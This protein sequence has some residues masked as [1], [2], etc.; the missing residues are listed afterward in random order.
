M[1]NQLAIRSA[2]L[3][4]LLSLSSAPMITS[5]FLA[6]V[7]VYVQRHLIDAAVLVTWF[8]LITFATIARLALARRYQHSPVTDAE[9]VDHRLKIFRIGMAVSGVIWGGAGIWLFP[10]NDPQHQMFLIFML[11]G[12]TAGGVVSY[13]ADRLSAVVFSLTVL[14][15]IDIKLFTVEANSYS[16]MG[17]A[18]TLY[19]I[20]LIITLRHIN[21]NT[22]DNIT[23]HLEATEREKVVKTSE[24]RY[25]LLLNYS[26][27]GIFHYDTNLIITYC[28][29]RFA[30]ILATTVDKLVGLDMNQL[31]DQAVL[32]ALKK[33]IAGELGR[34][35]GLY[36]S[37]LSDISVWIDM[38]CAPF[39]DEAAGQVRGG[40]GIVQDITER[41]QAEMELH[42]SAI[43]FES[44][45]GMMITDENS[46]ILRVNKAF[47]QITGY[48]VEEVT[49]VTPQILSS[50]NH[51][52]SF[53]EDMWESV[54]NKG[55]WEGEIWNRRKNG[56]IYPEHLTITAVP[57]AD[58]NIMNYVGTLMDITLSKEAEEEIKNLAF[59]DSLTGLP[60][61]R[62]LLDRLN[63]ALAVSSRSGKKGAVLFL[64]LDNFKNLNDTLGHDTGDLLLQ[65]VAKRLESC[66]RED[67]TVARLGGDEFVIMLE[68]LS[69]K[70]FEAAAQ[71]DV[72]GE[73]ILASI[74]QPYQLGSHSYHSSSSIGITII[75][76]HETETD[77][78]LK[79]ADIAMYQAKKAGRDNLTFF[80]PQMQKS[81]SE[82]VS[83]ETDL[84]AAQAKEQFQLYYQPQ[85]DR[86]GSFIGVEVL[87][88]WIHPDRGLVSPFDFIPLAEETGLILPI[89]HWVMET[90]CNQLKAWAADDD[91]QHLQ[92]SVNVSARQFHQSDFVEV[93][94]EI[95][96]QSAIQ[97]DKL[98]LELTE[99]LVLDDIDDT[100]Q[101]MHAL[102]D[103]GVRFSMDDFGTGHS[104]L[105][106]L[107]KLPLDELKI[108]QSFVRDIMEDSDD[109]IIVQ[110]IIAMATNLGM[111]VIAEGVETDAQRTFLE[112]HGC[113]YY[114]GYLFGRPEPL[115]KFEALLKT[116]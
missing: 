42:I 105:A 62:L 72:V 85:V 34:F 29:T 50:G 65:Q 41:K 100:I 17:V 71:T 26:P 59:Y 57:N 19:L 27:V 112:E 108:D 104:S 43:A 13:S 22:I 94:Q 48:S 63:H 54:K 37:T 97:P 60:N 114:Q 76:G 67:D 52:I 61:R 79:Q 47:T 116:S 25:R 74:N 45:Q 56:E 92:L 96:N 28:N 80:D 115:D 51:D 40:I 69:E 4:Q 64:D 103:L 78:L 9:T 35:E 109:A 107:K 1:N 44:Q 53:Y 21:R 31:K 102:R 11:A 91:M 14:I 10:E 89:G 46:A 2:Q 58:G 110:T 75:E 15:P 86:D 16:A 111:K 68:N 77:E 39:K 99:S 7:L 23:L 5:I 49:G 98:K 93:V 3:Q 18:L 12:L 81:V 6:M 32:P 20:F 87:I 33:V 82:R 90:A 8:S 83:L 95:L 113:Y 30:D 101:K 55:T 24:E 38:T 84:R 70:G 36:Q 73:K 66:V 88:R 106:S